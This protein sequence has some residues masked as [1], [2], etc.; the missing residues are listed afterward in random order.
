MSRDSVDVLL[1]GEALVDIVAD[2]A[3]PGGSP[4]NVAVGLSRLGVRAE[5]ATR[6]GTDRYGALLAKHLTANGVRLS[7]GSQ[8][9]SMRTATATATL[10]PDGV[11]SYE[12]EIDWQPPALLLPSGCAAVHTGSIGAALP[13]GAAAVHEFVASLP[14][15]PVTV[16]FDPNVRPTITPDAEQAWASVRDLAACSDL[17]KLSDEDCAFLQPRLSPH[18]VAAELLAEPRTRCVVVTLGG[19]GALGVTR[20]GTVQVG[21]SKVDVVDTVGAGDSFMSALLAGL[22]DH[23]LLGER[24]LDGLSETTLSDVVRYAA[25]AA[26]ITCTRRGADPPTHAEVTAAL[27]N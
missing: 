7:P 5:L 13:P 8:D 27:E 20:S 15:A 2:A 25:T 18:Q 16:T 9:A 24:R 3:T 17:V 26:G 22:R 21:A 4:T 12:F 1:V 6:F 14:D 19:S 23:E 11:A 10:T